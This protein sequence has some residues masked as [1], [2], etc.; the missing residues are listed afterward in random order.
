[1]RLVV[2]AVMLAACAPVETPAPR[3]APIAFALDQGGV[4]V[5]GKPLRID[6]GRTD[7]STIPAM[8]KLVG[9]PPA[10]TRNC[11]SGGAL[12][13]WPDGTG[14][15]MAQGEFRGWVSAASGTGAGLTCSPA[16]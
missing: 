5:L 4:Q 3:S 14:F 1:M 13:I 6:F 11:T 12:V 16:A 7:H 15:V 9:Q 2:A 8:T 10:T